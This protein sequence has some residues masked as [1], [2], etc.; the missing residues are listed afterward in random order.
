MPNLTDM[1]SATIEGVASAAINYTI[2]SAITP[3]MGPIGG[4]IAPRLFSTTVQ[5]IATSATA[6]VITKGIITCIKTA[7]NHQSENN[8]Q[9]AEKPLNEEFDDTDTP[10]Q[11][12]P[13]P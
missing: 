7:A 8:P 2:Y 13:G 5:T 4:A 11:T 1:A 9:H 10:L 6:T 3:F 12:K